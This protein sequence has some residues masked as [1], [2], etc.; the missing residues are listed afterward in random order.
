PCRRLFEGIFINSDGNV[1]IC[2]QDVNSE[3]IICSMNDL[4]ANIYDAGLK[5]KL[6]AE[7]KKHCE[8][9]Y[10][11]FCKNCDQWYIPLI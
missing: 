5:E 7:K 2:D 10:G 4:N 8:E 6:L 3:S 1:C 11:D 9:K